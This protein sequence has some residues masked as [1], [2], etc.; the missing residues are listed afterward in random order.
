MDL[1]NSLKNQ[2]IPGSLVVFMMSVG[3]S[4]FAGYDPNK[5]TTPT[6]ALGSTVLT[7]FGAQ[8]W[9]KNF[10]FLITPSL[11]IF[12]F[13]LILY[14]VVYPDDFK[15]SVINYLRGVKKRMKENNN[16]N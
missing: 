2:I 8:D 11:F 15:K 14:I 1:K 4:S 12:I 6:K 10:S 7:I 3:L 5:T 9:G 13:S 16:L